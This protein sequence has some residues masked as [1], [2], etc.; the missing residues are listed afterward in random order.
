M[1]HFFLRNVFRFLVTGALGS[2]VYFNI[3]IVPGGHLGVLSD[4]ITGL[5]TPL[6]Q[7]GY[8]WRWTGFAPGKW[9]Y[10][11]VRLTPPPM[12]ITST[13]SRLM[14]IEHAIPR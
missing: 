8:S 6:L 12:T 14:R 11:P 9:F 3:I 1:I 5:E 10:Y 7:P 4:K 2:L 13:L